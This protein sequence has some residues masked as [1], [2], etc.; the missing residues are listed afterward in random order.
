ML[1]FKLIE[2][3]LNQT[4]FILEVEMDS[5]GASIPVG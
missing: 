2:E 3:I 1:A 4:F 5:V